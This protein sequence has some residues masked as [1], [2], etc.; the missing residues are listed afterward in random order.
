MK[1]KFIAILLLICTSAFPQQI[2][3]QRI[4]QMPN[5]PAPYLMRNWKDVTKNYDSLV[6]NL[7]SSGQ[8]LP[9]V[10][11]YNNTVNYPGHG[12]FGL[13]SYVGTNRYH[14]AEAINIIPAV[15]GA[16]L[17]GIDKSNQNGN[18]W[19][20]WCEEYFNKKNSEN[21]YLN[22]P[23]SSSG[24]DWW[25]AT[26]PNVFFYQLY[27]LYPNTG[28]F[29]NQFNSVAD[30]WLQSVQAMGGSAT[31]WSIPNMDYRGWY[32]ATM[33]PNSQDVH[34]PESAGA[35]SW[36]LYNAYAETKNTK[37]RI[38]AELA[39][40]FLNNYNTNPAYE[41][42]L[43]YG[44]YTA[45][46]MNAELGTNYDIAKMLNW[47]FNVGPL[48]SWGSILGNWNGYDVSGLIGEVSSNDYAFI[49]NG[50]QQA[51]ALV[52][53][54]RYDNRF[55]KA[56][57]KWVLN[58]ANASRLF[59]TNYLPDVNQD[60]KSWANLYDPKSC[61][62]HEALRKQGLANNSPYAT[63]DAISGGWANTNLSLYSSS[64]V[65][66]LASLIDTTNID[67]ILKI[68]LLKTD[69]FHSPAYPTYLF[70]NPYSVDKTVTINIISGSCDVY[71][72]ITRTF[73]L[74]NV[75]GNTSFSI[76]ADGVVVAVLIPTGSTITYSGNKTLA[77]NVVI[78]FRTKEQFVNVLRIKSIASDK[79]L[80]L[81]SDSANIYCTLDNMKSDVVNYKW[82]CNGGNIIN[83]TANPVKWN[84]P[85]IPG[86]YSV[87]CTALCA[88][89]SVT[90]T[91]I[92][93][94]TET[95]HSTPSINRI[96]AIPGKINPSA[97]CNITCEA[98]D[99]GNS[100]LTYKWASVYGQLSGS[101]SA[102]KWQAPAVKGDYY[103]SCKVTNS[104]GE[105]ATDS[106]AIMVRD[107]SNTPKGN[108]VAYY[109]F[110]G[111]ANDESG[112][113]NNGTSYGAVSVNDRNNNANSAYFFNGADAYIQAPNSASLN[114]QD[115]I[116]VS[117]WLNV[118][119]FYN[120]EAYPVSHGNWENRWKISV[121][122]NR[123]RWTVKTN[124]GVK[125]LDSKTVLQA[126]TYYDVTA[127]YNGEDLELYIN[128]ELDN[129]T[130]FTGLINTTTYD[131]TIGQ[132]LP[133]NKNYNFNGTIDELR[134][135]N[136]ALSQEEI[137][138]LYNG[139]T[140]IINNNGNNGA[141]KY[142]LAQ[143]YPNPFNPSTTIKYTVPNSSE[144]K[145][146]LYD[147]IGREVATLYNG[148]TSAGEHSV[149]LDANKYNLA[150]GIYFYKIICGSF[151]Q[152]HKMNLI[153]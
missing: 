127:C 12:S 133:G 84:A 145:I 45:A 52:P 106:V 69:F 19:V 136:Y 65:G 124:T 103:V 122:N 97:G 33:T 149:S 153:K 71:N 148:Y 102:V 25:Y 150:S 109:P 128:G 88:G 61:I 42:Q 98:V 37:Y 131:L 152:T 31:P 135:Y 118:G 11:V 28:D 151:T 16:S 142:S 29:N 35:I 85:A 110:N 94:V 86:K 114:F 34:E 119:Q 13:D 125:D 67:K 116:T 144:V 107:L 49:M 104:F 64:H 26:M 55:A 123:I 74:N 60:S 44:I 30:R 50:F 143:N 105:S 27:S 146:K 18:N 139:A 73:I 41:I 68:D 101:G 95:P 57:G 48:R 6:F 40:E 23:S 117:L 100:I 22:S 83:G 111:N 3:I 121:T 32:L 36:L 58:L 99:T 62:A 115:S 63:G 10:W 130:P 75:S 78:D 147:V 9:L 14:S 43:P 87:I 129:F 77:N 54:V 47:S 51:A 92:M 59:Y 134:I 5:I 21:V 126:N 70:Y 91:L 108:L 66:Y 1:Y 132:V 24:S 39:M 140:G 93:L 2:S 20:L 138:K 137:L 17:N 15:V 72:S 113:G 56:I 90:D 96:K 7:N 112:F 4:D 82:S 46:R 79:S 38:G 89:E 141:Y 81:S 76:P 80:L 8:Y 120:R 53:M